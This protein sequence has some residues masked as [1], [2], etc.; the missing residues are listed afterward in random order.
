MSHMQYTTVE[1]NVVRNEGTLLGIAHGFP[2]KLQTSY[3]HG[4]LAQSVKSVKQQS[5]T[6]KPDPGFSLADAFQFGTSKLLDAHKS[7]LARNSIVRKSS[8]L[9][10]LSWLCKRILS[11]SYKFCKTGTFPFFVVLLS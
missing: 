9:A 8:C 11:F 7:Q 3:A 5:N 2:M 4:I 1:D 6:M 10:K